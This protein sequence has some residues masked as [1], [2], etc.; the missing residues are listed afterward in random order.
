MASARPGSEVEV[1]IQQLL[2][3]LVAP[4][5]Q[6]DGGDVHFESFDRDS[7][8]LT[9]RLSGACVDCPSATMTMRFMIN[10]VITHYVPE[11]TK[12][13]RLGVPCDLD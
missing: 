3:D 12:V 4:N 11:V 6:K 13:V 7:G 2:D 5:V 1:H 8:V 10:N 9:I